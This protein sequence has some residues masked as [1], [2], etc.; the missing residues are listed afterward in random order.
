M[1][2]IKFRA[3]NK[4]LKKFLEQNII[5]K[6]LG[7]WIVYNPEH[8]QDGDIILSQFTG[9][10]DK[11]GKEIWEGDIIGIRKKIMAVIEWD[12][13]TARFVTRWTSEKVQRIRKE[14]H[15]DGLPINLE[16]VGSPWEVIGNIYENEDLL[17]GK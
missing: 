10:H 3:W 7:D 16:S 17:G 5:A 1:R 11:N 4:E 13:R 14:T 2:E 6:Y 12:R 15:G 9:L 8:Y